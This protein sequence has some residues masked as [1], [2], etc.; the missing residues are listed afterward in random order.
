MGD[1]RRLYE[2]LGRHKADALIAA[3]GVELALAVVTG[4][5]DKALDEQVEVI[6]S[7][8]LQ[9]DDTL[10]NIREQVKEYV[11][12]AN[13]DLLV[14]WLGADYALALATA[15]EPQANEHQLK[16]RYKSVALADTLGLRWRSV[17]FWGQRRKASPADIA[18]SMTALQKV[19]DLGLPINELVALI[20]FTGDVARAEQVMD[21]MLNR[22]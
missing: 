14:D 11:G 22:R 13:G 19:R 1:K 20:S 8:A 21:I 10:V 5:L 2:V 4:D 6:R 7:K 18:Q 15:R 12:Q 17:A 16:A 3:L 9:K